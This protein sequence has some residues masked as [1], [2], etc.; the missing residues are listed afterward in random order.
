[1][2]EGHNSLPYHRIEWWSGTCFRPGALWEVGLHLTVPHM[3]GMCGELESHVENVILLELDHDGCD[4]TSIHHQDADAID[5]TPRGTGDKSWFDVNANQEDADDELAVDEFHDYLD[6]HTICDD[7]LA[8]SLHGPSTIPRMDAFKNPF[9]RI[10][11][12]NGVHHL[13]LITCACRGSD[14]IPAD[15]MFHGLVPTTFTQ[16]RTLATIEVLDHIRHANLDLKASSWQYHRL[17]RR[18][19]QPLPVQG[20]INLY[21]ELRRLSREWRWMKKLKW[22]GYGHGTF[23]SDGGI[24]FLPDG[25]SEPGTRGSGGTDSERAG[26]NSHKTGPAPSTAGQDTAHSVQPSNAPIHLG[27]P[28]RPRAGSLA[29]FCAACPQAGVNL[30]PDWENDPNQ[31]VYTRFVVL[32]GNFKADHVRQKADDND[33]IWLSNGGG[34][35]ANQVD[36]HEFIRTARQ[37]RS[38][39]VMS[40]SLFSLHSCLSDG[41][42]RMHP[43][44]TIFRF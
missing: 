23:L 17:L 29:N 24:D 1:M 14:D 27:D 33:D 13:P 43:V 30:C 5:R 28:L 22:A 7:D 6:P 41:G 21:K 44:K 25:T 9:V 42:T 3:S 19:T 39:R 38:V 8:G 36:Y 40:R 34:M 20:N 16:F 12:V 18:Q 10:I 15:L 2:R 35:F 4:Q 11:H 31:W 32:D 26:W 37:R